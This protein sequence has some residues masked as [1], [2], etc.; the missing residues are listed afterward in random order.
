MAVR[1]SL[2]PGMPY[3]PLRRLAMLVV[4][5]NPVAE[6]GVGDGG[7]M[8]VYVREMAR[9]LA[10]RGLEVDIYTRHDAGGSAV[11]TELSPGVVV[12]PIVAGEPGLSKAELPAHL[13]EFTANL[14][15]Q[16]E[17]RL[18]GYDLIH[19]H[20]WLSGRVATLLAGR[21][22]IPFVHTFHTLGLVKNQ[23]RARGEPVEPE[24]RLRGEARVIAEAEAIIA[25]SPQERSWLIDL[26]AAH[27]ERIHVIPPG[28]D[29]STFRP[30]AGGDRVA[31]KVALG[32]ALGMS[33]V[34]QRDL[35][36]KHVLLF[37]GRLQP[38]KGA[39]T[40]IEALAHLIGW[41]RVEPEGAVL[42][43]VGGGSGAAGA[44]EPERLQ[45][46]AT[47]LGVASAVR[48]VDAQPHAAL[49]GFYQAADVC[50]V[51]SYTES[52]GLVAL[53]AQAS[54]TPVIGSAVGGLRS[55]VRHGQTGYL[56]SPGAAGAFAERAWRVLSD[57]PLA[58]SMSRL[59]VCSSGD[60]SWDQ[61][62]TDLHD[63]YVASTRRARR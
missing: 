19:S 52:F 34:E 59:A 27:P 6:P 18:V 13:P 16:V 36:H 43:V 25:S 31:A 1:E 8:T 55:I 14:A 21:W 54:G 41:G 20:Y 9:A 28:V 24:A 26:Y 48:F 23:G 29:H 3:R 51:P 12:Y 33:P 42:L 45:A 39:G 17:Q 4:H 58:A 44:G 62:G 56:V 47:R 15:A 46:L 50:F 63:L 40:A 7:G 10:R 35:S 57:P 37:A 61:S 5:S 49:P 32:K 22:G 2:V 11:P 30:P 60:F 53:E 38:L